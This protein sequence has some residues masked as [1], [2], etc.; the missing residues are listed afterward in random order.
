MAEKLKIRYGYGRVLFYLA[1]F[2]GMLCMN[3]TM[4]N[5]EPFSLAPLVAALLC[6]ANPVAAAG[7]YIL[8]GGLAFTVGGF[9]FLAIAVSGVLLCGI[10]LFYERTRRTMRAEIALYLIAA[11]APFVWIFGTVVYANLIRALLVAA[12]IFLLC[13]VFAGAMRCALFRLGRRK[14]TP[15]DPMLCAAA[16]A[17]A[18]IGLYNLAG[19]YAYEGIALLC[20]LLCCS[21]MRN[22]NAALCALALSLPIAICE[23]V[24]AAAPV[25]TSCGLFALY[26]AIILVFLRAGKLP[27]ALALFFANVTARYFTDFFA[28]ENL[29][30]PFTASAFY[31][32]M[33]V[34]LIPCLLYAMVPDSW[35]SRLSARARQFNERRLTRASIN[36]NR[37]LVGEK[38]FEIS[39][40]FREIEVAFE[41]L[42]T[43]TQAE[44][45]A[46]EFLL[47]EL[48]K[49]VCGGCEK[50]EECGKDTAEGLA[51]LVSVGCA[52][53]KV[54]L[55]DLP[56]A[57][58]SHCMNPSS[59]LFS[60]NKLLAEYRRGSIEAEN[61]AQGRKLLA[62]HA[63]GLADMLK[64]LAVEQSAPLGAY[65][66]T[67]RRLK[68]ALGRAGIACDEV[69]VCGEPAE[70]YITAAHATG[71]KLCRAAE[72]V[73][74]FPL[75][76]S[77]KRALS[78]DRHCWLLRR[79][80][81]FDA[82]FGVSSVTKE[83]E[84]ACGDT[85]SLTRIDERTF[86]CALSDGMGS[87]EYARR[88]SDCSLSLIESFY[89]AGLSGEIV[90][91][92]VNRLLSF[93]REESFACIDAAA[94]DLETGR[95]DIVKV[96]S[97]LGFLLSETSMELLESDSLPLGL[98]DGVRPSVLTRQ[99]Q[100][101]DALLFI[102]DGITSAFGSSADIAEF[103]RTQS[104][105]N[106][107]A[108]TDALLAAALARTGGHAE[109]DMTAVA[110]R[111][112]DRDKSAA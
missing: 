18:G 21:L 82:M 101:G 34:P 53:G 62:E 76:V 106:P 6:G 9:P 40:A 50:R 69:L 47:S 48:Q 38:L 44:T 95:A 73:F 29:T 17:A 91:S 27:A 3:F 25:L 58:S 67:E 65:A 112:F 70:I 110:V 102:S 86:L 105:A 33:L 22:G 100:G 109:D 59:L 51:K 71:E 30:A 1:L 45:D 5:F 79:R 85:S 37:A 89:R 104:A 81:H 35:L 87:G 93:N 108:L 61:A 54:N 28:P 32:T 60:L 14:L 56:A 4:K 96:G 7:T 68:D 111:L 74:N 46:R 8:A 19:A 98:L 43:D 107:Q 24:E 97:P 31:L 72:R 41:T 13:F 10:F 94:V 63:R 36:R 16:V 77:S 2:L 12:A 90:L 80:P 23:S 20:L 88:I 15:E 49:E 103:L 39:A 52:K 55:I 92:T 84:S 11:L 78:A 66:E 83:G 42:D 57:L 26:A 64:N 75:T 99:L